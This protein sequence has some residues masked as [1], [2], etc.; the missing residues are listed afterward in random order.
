VNLRERIELLSKHGDN[1]LVQSLLR[2]L[3]QKHV[4]LFEEELYDSNDALSDLVL[5]LG[6]ELSWLGHA[7][8]EMEQR[9]CCGRWNLTDLNDALED[10]F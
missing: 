6:V 4:A 8:S 9:G 10:H 5:L 7:L 3:D 1:A 2:G